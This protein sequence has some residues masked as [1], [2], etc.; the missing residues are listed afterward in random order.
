M[1]SKTISKEVEQ[2]QE[3]TT[4]KSIARLVKKY[5]EREDVEC[6]YFLPY[7]EE[8]MD[9]MYYIIVILSKLSGEIEESFKKYN[10]SHSSA[11]AIENFG[12]EIQVLPDVAWYY[13]ET[14]MG[15]NDDEDSTTIRVNDLLNGSILYDKTGK[16]HKIVEELLEKPK[17][18]VKDTIN[19]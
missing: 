6:I 12:G 19:N 9:N 7:I 8:A 10:K 17:E 11:K 3:D 1:I 14:A 4:A 13:N 2:R 15:I 16:Y 5:K 18:K